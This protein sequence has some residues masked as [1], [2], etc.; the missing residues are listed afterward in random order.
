MFHWVMR[1]PEFAEFTEFLFRLG[2]TPTIKFNTA[3][4]HIW[5]ANRKYN[6]FFGGYF[7]SKIKQQSPFVSYPVF[8]CKLGNFPVRWR[9]LPTLGVWHCLSFQWMCSFSNL[10]IWFKVSIRTLHTNCNEIWWIDFGWRKSSIGLTDL[11]WNI[12]DEFR[13]DF[14]YPHETNTFDPPRPYEGR[15]ARLNTPKPRPQTDKF[16]EP[17]SDPTY[18]RYVSRHICWALNLIVN[19]VSFISW[20]VVSLRW[21]LVSLR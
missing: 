13:F 20:K 11:Y 18:T 3:R 6:L 8:R 16:P 17:E 1:F 12:C 2:K 7:Q 19:C 21:K 10:P 4:H 9:W 14:Q 5:L 15:I